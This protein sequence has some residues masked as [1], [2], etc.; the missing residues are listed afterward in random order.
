MPRRPA[1]ALI[2]VPLLLPLLLS[3]FLGAAAPSASAGDEHPAR[4]PRAGG[5]RRGGGYSI[6]QAISDRAQLTTIAFDGLA[7]L[8][9]GFGQDTFFPPGKVC[10]Y[11]GFQ[12]LR[13]V[14]QGELGHNSLFLPRIADNLLR[15]LTAE[16]QARLVALAREQAP[17][18]EEFARRRFV[19]IRAFRRLLEGDVP[20][21]SPGLDPEAVATYVGD[22]YAL[23][24]EVA[25]RRAQVTGAIFR[26]LG[27]AQTKALSALKFGDSRT[28]PEVPEAIDRRTMSHR[29]HVAVMTYA[30]EMFS[31][32]TGSLEADVYFCPERHGTYFGGFY[33]KDMPAMRNPGTNISTSLTGDAGDAFLAALD[34]RQRALVTGLVDAQ[35]GELV[36]IVET[37]RAI[38]VELRRFL[39]EDAAN[40]DRV[41]ALASAYG[42][43]DGTLSTRY[44]AAFAAVA[45]TLTAEQ[46]ATLDRLRNLPGDV[47]RG[48][49]LYSDPIPTP[50]V[51]DSD[52]LFAPSRAG[53]PEPIPTR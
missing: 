12:Y 33:M 11:F 43:L 6:D 21:G 3:G 36:Q 45:R 46:K 4:P 38:A 13:D 20:E 42:R 47:C 17:R 51:P 18:I 24:G 8:T 48:A 19:V 16:Q 53:S 2:I 22:L 27:D 52:A 15:V 34:A 49:F 25:W 30:S 5:P 14:D 32:W 26:S 37:R 39:V 41:V 29:E 10:D 31:W 35:R 9:G 23:D 28:W 40:H 50:P 1:A 7:F 44:A